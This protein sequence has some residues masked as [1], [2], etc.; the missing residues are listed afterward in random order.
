MVTLPLLCVRFFRVGNVGSVADRW[1]VG[2]CA[3]LDDTVAA[4]FL[5]LAGSR[6]RHGFEPDSSCLLSVDSGGG[7]WIRKAAGAALCDLWRRSANFT[8]LKPWFERHGDAKPQLVNMY[9]I[10][11]TTVHVTYRPLVAADAKG[12]T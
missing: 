3:V 1:P 10:T 2:D 4:R 9:G 6:K 7:V 12:D 5:Q 11:E 8:N